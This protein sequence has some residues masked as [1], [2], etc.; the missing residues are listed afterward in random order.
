MD[1]YRVILGKFESVKAEL[2]IRKKELD[3]EKIR[4]EYDKRMLLYQRA[5]RENLLNITK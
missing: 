2:E 5:D 1:N 4:L 3:D